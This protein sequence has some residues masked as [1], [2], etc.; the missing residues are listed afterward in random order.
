MSDRP[1][2]APTDDSRYQLLLLFIKIVLWMFILFIIFA[3]SVVIIS[4]L[5][6]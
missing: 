4:K 1:E 3:V 6:K 5:A 2:V